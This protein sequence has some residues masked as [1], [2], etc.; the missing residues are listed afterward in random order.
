MSPHPFLLLAAVVL[1]S[2][3]T[4]SAQNSAPVAV[5]FQ[6]DNVAAESGGLRRLHVSAGFPPRTE[7]I[8]AGKLLKATAD[9]GTDLMPQ[10]KARWELISSPSTLHMF[11]ERMR[12]NVTIPLRTFDSARVQGLRELSGIFTCMV[13]DWKESDLGFTKFAAGQMG[14]V[15]KAKIE[16]IKPWTLSGGTQTLSIYLDVPMDA[17]KDFVVT[18]TAGQPIPC[19]QM[20][21]GPATGGSLTTFLLKEGSFPPAG[22]IKAQILEGKPVEMPFKFAPFSLTKATK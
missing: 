9:D 17:V 21:Q 14:K 6:L 1:A 20:Q 22:K 8:L 4:V 2:I 16:A 13:G 7:L 18:D 12:N 11:R 19:R 3:S 5:D 15:H 10:D